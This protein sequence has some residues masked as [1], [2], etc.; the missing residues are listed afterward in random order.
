MVRLPPSVSG[1]RTAEALI[2]WPSSTT[3]ILVSWAKV[4]PENSASSATTSSLFMVI[5]RFPVRRSGERRVSLLSARRI[6]DVGALHVFRDSVARGTA[7]AVHVVVEADE[8]V[9][10][11]IDQVAFAAIGGD[12]LG[13]IHRGSRGGVLGRTRNRGRARLL[14]GTLGGTHREYVDQA[15]FD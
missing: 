8:A 2:S 15:A 12:G 5:S 7:D 11:A 13:G 10:I 9:A 1:R 6:D 4:P 14:L 3:F